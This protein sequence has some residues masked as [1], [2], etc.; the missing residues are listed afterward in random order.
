MPKGFTFVS[1]LA[2]AVSLAL[3]VAVSAEPAA[4]TVVA[5]VNGQEITLGNMIVA[6][7]T[8]PQ[9]YQQ[10]PPDVLYN[11]ILNQLV[12][13]TALVQAHGPEEPLHVKLSLENERRSLLA[14]DEIEQIIL[15]TVTDAGVFGPDY[16]YGEGIMNAFAAV[17]WALTAGELTGNR[18]IPVAVARHPEMAP[19]VA[20]SFIGPKGPLPTLSVEVQVT[21]L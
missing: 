10:L 14:A 11:A 21:A 17:R 18:Y 1:A 2:F 20:G 6:Y 8:L 13:Q 15:S 16:L 5:R 7:A 19:P 3:P 9:Q 4:D 12:Q